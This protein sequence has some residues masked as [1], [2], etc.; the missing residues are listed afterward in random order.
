M[1]IL[2]AGASGKLGSRLVQDLSL[3]HEVTALSH[4][5]VDTGCFVPTLA[6]VRTIHPEVILNAAAFTAVDRCEDEP[7][8][9]YSGNAVAVRNLAT[10]A[11]EVHAHLIHFSTDFVFDGMREGPPYREYDAVN[12]LSVYGKSKLAGEVEALRNGPASTVLRL[13]WL[14]GPG[15]W[16][17]TDW[18]VEEAKSGR[19]VRI[20]TDQIGTPTWVGD[21]ASQVKKL[22]NERV[23]GIYHCAGQGACSRYEWACEAIRL[24]GLDP[25]S[26]IPIRSG[27]FA[28]K[29]PRP[30]YSALDNFFLRAQDLEV[31]RPW[32]EALGD[33]LKSRAC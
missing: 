26:V 24:A 14:Y 4:G 21:V 23:Q 30:K 3:D 27:E 2:I 25:S 13:S 19:P 17:F 9:A 28:Q 1:K 7:D 10:S 5:D 18:V 15:A 33:H 29:A 22:L 8:L 12:P 16:N 6:A 11:A 32:Q 20:F 31:M